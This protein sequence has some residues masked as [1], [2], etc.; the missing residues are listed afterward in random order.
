[1]RGPAGHRERGRR[2]D[3][4]REQ[5]KGEEANGRRCEEAN[6]R[7]GEEA[8]GEEEKGRRGGWANGGGGLAVPVELRLP[9]AL[10]GRVEQICIEAAARAASHGNGNFSGEALAEP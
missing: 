8:R 7:S 2:R 6:G 9:S 4:G 1:M 10:C 3:E 5:G